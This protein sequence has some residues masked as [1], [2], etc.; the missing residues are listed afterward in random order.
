MVQCT[1]LDSSSE[2]TPSFSRMAATSPSRQ[3][4]HTHTSAVL[5]AC[6][7]H[8][9]HCI[10]HVFS[11]EESS[12]PSQLHYPIHLPCLVRIVP[13]KSLP[14]KKTTACSSLG[15]LQCV[16][17]GPLSCLWG[18]NSY[19]I[20]LPCLVCIAPS[21]SLPRKKATSLL[22]SGSQS[23][24][25]ICTFGNT[26]KV[27]RGS[28]SV[29][30]CMVLAKGKQKYSEWFGHCLGCHSGCIVFDL[31]PC[32][33]SLLRVARDYH[34]KWIVN[35]LYQLTITADHVIIKEHK[36]NMTTPVNHQ[37]NGR[38]KRV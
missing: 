13:S 33:R 1:S 2:D 37:G 30:G 11:Y 14:T 12:F 16:R 17:V 27:N 22:F 7:L 9:L 5:F 8:D 21:K 24:S 25:E 35:Y 32:Y 36:M 26:I 34:Y 15:R 10:I 23:W 4:L 6:Y 28:I 18:E 3:R 29:T 20:R 31:C 38:M 19:P